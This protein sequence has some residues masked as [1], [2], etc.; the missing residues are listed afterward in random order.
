ML[1]TLTIFQ[2]N[3]AQINL[4]LQSDTVKKAGVHLAIFW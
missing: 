2:K 4:F 1:A 3:L